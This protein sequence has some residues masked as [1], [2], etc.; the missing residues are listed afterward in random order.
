MATSGRRPGSG[1]SLVPAKVKD[2][3]WDGCCIVARDCPAIR[4]ASGAVYAIPALNMKINSAKAAATQASAP[5][6]LIFYRG[7]SGLVAVIGKRSA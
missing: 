4:W 6:P 2:N 5:T 3:F 1:L 7:V